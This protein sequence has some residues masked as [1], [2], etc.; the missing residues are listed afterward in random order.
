MTT[1]YWIIGV[2]AVCALA[3]A[4]FVHLVPGAD[5]WDA[6]KP[7]TSVGKYGLLLLFSPIVV[8]FGTVIAGFEYSRIGWRWLIGRPLWLDDHDI[9][10]R[11][12]KRRQKYDEKI[13]DEK[14]S[15]W[16]GRVLW[17]QPE[18]IIYDITK[19]CV[20]LE[21]DGVNR[22]I[23]WK[24]LE[25]FRAE[26]GTGEVPS[27]PMLLEYVKYRLEIEAPRYL[28]FGEKL[29]QQ[30]LKDCV[31]HARYNLDRPKDEVDYPPARQRG[32]KLSLEEIEKLGVSNTDHIPTPST[33]HRKIAHIKFRLLDGDEVWTYG[34]SARNGVALVRDGTSI[35][36]V[37]TL[38]MSRHA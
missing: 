35:D 9:L 36:H 22:Q 6:S 14:I 17:D 37:T 23:I 11:L 30:Q 1:V 13:K 31:A 28:T 12:V 32:R 7:K 27:S 21:S 24:K 34:N 5:I 38:Y 4:A 10:E 2:W 8:S 3:C 25:A 26:F 20:T 29:L 33:F 18:D 19:K 16:P 15:D